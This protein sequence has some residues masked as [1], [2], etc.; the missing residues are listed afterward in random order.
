MIDR[1]INALCKLGDLMAEDSAERARIIEKAGHSNPW[2]TRENVLTAL[3]GI[4]ANLRQEEIETWLEPY[5]CQLRQPERPLNIGLV[6]AGNIPMVGFHDILGVLVSGPRTVIKLSSMDTEH[7]SWMH[8][9]LGDD[10]QEKDTRL[11]CNT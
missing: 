9:K 6:L 11:K 1:Q 10:E 4:T 7:T 5:A 3:N 2:F 8:V